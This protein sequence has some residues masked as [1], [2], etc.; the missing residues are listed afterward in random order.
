MTTS[1]IR[2]AF[3][4]ACAIL[5][6]SATAIANDKADCTAALKSAQTLKTA[7]S[8][9]Q[10]LKELA[11]CARPVCPKAMQK[12]CSDLSDAVKASQPTVVF[13]AKD[14]S[15]KPVTNVKVTVDG[16]E[17]TSLLDGN[18]IGLDPGSHAMTFEM[19]GATTVTK[20]I[21]IEAVTKGQTIAVDLDANPPPPP[22]PVASG[23]VAP[24]PTPGEPGSMTDTAEDPSKRYYFIGL[25]YRGDVVPAFMLH[26]FV[27]GGK[28]LYSNSI[29]A[30]IDLRH[31]NFSLIPTITYSEYGTGD[32]LF[33]QKGKDADQAGYWSVVNSGLKGIYASADLLWSVNIA[34]HWQFEYGAEFGLGAIFGSLETNWVTSNSAVFN[35]ANA[36][37]C[38]TV[39]NNLGQ[40][41]CNVADHSGATAPGHINGYTE[42]SWVNG[43]SK[44]NIFPLINFPQLGLRYKPIKQM[45]ARFGLGFSL[46]GFW[47]GMS[48]DYGLEKPTK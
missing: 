14:A 4:S 41:G 25:K 19:E 33:L 16:N 9:S 42:P 44:P 2:A 5:L 8:L 6:P 15:G 11:T 35:P 17:V 39:N 40:S 1:A 31:D 26:L 7:G 47:F 46:T 23:V 18:A 10:S 22:P 34:D 13:S 30:E 32:L 20:Q 21:A 27:D 29:A 48:A 24:A 45:E 12:Q 28:T 3:L 38:S 37:A 43:G 36:K